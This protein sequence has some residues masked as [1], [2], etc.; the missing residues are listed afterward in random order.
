MHAFPI[1]AQRQQYVSTFKVSS[2]L[3]IESKDEILTHLDSKVNI[4]S[5]I[6]SSIQIF[7]ALVQETDL[8]WECIDGCFETGLPVLLS[9]NGLEK[10][11][12]IGS[13]NLWLGHVN[14][15]FAVFIF[16][17]FA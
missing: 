10:F 5:S 12:K 3:I 4:K 6:D 7:K 8:E 15:R 11:K 16:Y 1:L 14:V 9:T 13:R 17:R 2:V